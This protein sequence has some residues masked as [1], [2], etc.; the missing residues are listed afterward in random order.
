MI[1]EKFNKDNGDVV[2]L[3]DFV[4]ANLNK[5]RNGIFDLSAYSHLLSG[6][7]AVR[8]IDMI[9]SSMYGIRVI[10]SNWRYR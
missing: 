3:L 1:I 5:A 2:Q 8:R 7:D 10:V 9:I 6:W 4:E